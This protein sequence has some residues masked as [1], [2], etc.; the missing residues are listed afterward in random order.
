[1]QKPIFVPQSS[2]IMH[3]RVVS[4][5]FLAKYPELAVLSVVSSIKPLL[6]P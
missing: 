5:N 3:S 1:M 6:E 2:E 4:A